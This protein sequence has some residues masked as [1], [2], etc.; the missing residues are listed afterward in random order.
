MTKLSGMAIVN[1]TP[2]AKKLTPLDIQAPRKFADPLQS[3]RLFEA[4][5]PTAV[6][7]DRATGFASASV[8]AAGGVVGSS[9]CGACSL[10][11][12]PQR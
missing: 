7:S 1:I 8:S 5:V 11:V 10:L 2:K 3:R 4:G 6:I 9:G 12:I